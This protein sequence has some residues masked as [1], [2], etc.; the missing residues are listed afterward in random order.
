MQR[1]LLVR[2]IA[3]TDL[4]FEPKQLCLLCPHAWRGLSDRV[5]APRHV[6]VQGICPQ[7]CQDE[8]SGEAV[9]AAY[10]H[11]YFCPPHCCS[12][13]IQPAAQSP[14]DACFVLRMTLRPFLPT[15]PCSPPFLV[16]ALSCVILR[17][18]GCTA[19]AFC[20]LDCVRS[21]TLALIKH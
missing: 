21:E 1:C 2:M 18:N 14:W 16:L 9:R 20:Y 17:S 19:S 15:R 3:I 7:G 6:G 10:N 5:T 11:P 13:S 12:S 8:R 4:S